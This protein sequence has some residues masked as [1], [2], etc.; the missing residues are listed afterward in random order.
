[1]RKKRTV[2]IEFDRIKITTTL[3]HKRRFWCELC[4]AEAEF[5]TKAEAFALVKVMEVQG[6][7]IRKECLHLYESKPTQLLICLTSIINSGN[8]LQIH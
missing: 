1:M 2:T 8:N 6:L 3:D 7:N 4:Q 5:I